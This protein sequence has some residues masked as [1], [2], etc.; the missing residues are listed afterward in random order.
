MRFTT[1]A[2]C[3]VSKSRARGVAH[4]EHT[5]LAVNLNMKLVSQKF[6]VNRGKFILLRGRKSTELTR[7]ILTFRGVWSSRSSSSFRWLK[8]W[9]PVHLSWGFGGFWLNSCRHR[10]NLSCLVDGRRQTHVQAVVVAGA[11]GGGGGG[12]GDEGGSE[13]RGGSDGRAA[14]SSGVGGENVA[15]PPP[16]SAA[17][18]S[19]LFCCTKSI[20][21]RSQCNAATWFFA[22]SNVFIISRHGVYLFSIPVCNVLSEATALWLPLLDE[23]LHFGC[24]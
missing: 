7:K 22:F 12:G 9:L 20:V 10:Q 11:E 21:P 4:V 1:T 24:K 18:Q 8:R 16:H 15:S 19:F 3:S 5:V 6:A 17:P 13:G 23:L 14:A 2:L